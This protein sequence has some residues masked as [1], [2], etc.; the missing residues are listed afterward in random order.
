MAV[1]DGNADDTGRALEK[2]EAKWK[3]DPVERT[4]GA[5]LA[6][7]EARAGIDKPARQVRDRIAAFKG[8]KP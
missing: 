1:A 3:I 7:L 8:L 2:L 4:I 6:A 5:R